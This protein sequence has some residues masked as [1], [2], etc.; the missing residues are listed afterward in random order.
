MEPRRFHPVIRERALVAKKRIRVRERQEALRNETLDVSLDKVEALIDGMTAM[1]LFFRPV[2]PCRNRGTIDAA[3][4]A[5]GA[6]R[7]RQNEIADHQRVRAR[8]KVATYGIA[9]RDY[10]RL[11]EEIE[12]RI[13]EDRRGSIFARLLQ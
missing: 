6:S 5:Q 7:L 12:R 11:A 2:H 4:V 3:L 10:Q 13:H 8:T 1:R 9:W